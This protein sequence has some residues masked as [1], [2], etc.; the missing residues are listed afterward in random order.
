MQSSFAGSEFYRVCWATTTALGV[1]SQSDSCHADLALATGPLKLQQDGL[2]DA[3]YGETNE[4][5][6]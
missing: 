5:W 3:E 1:C 4:F 6:V 2:N